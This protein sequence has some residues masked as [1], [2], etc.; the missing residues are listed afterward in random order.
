MLP[1]AV[2]AHQGRPSAVHAHLLH[3]VWDLLLLEQELRR[4]A[5]GAPAVVVA[6]EHQGRLL[7]AAESPLPCAERP[8]MALSI[9]FQKHNR[10]IQ[11]KK[12]TEI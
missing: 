5:E 1:S 10:T 3:P 6:P 9:V 8:M 12:Y 2:H 11:E 4:P 7:V